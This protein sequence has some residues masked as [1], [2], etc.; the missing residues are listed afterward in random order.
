[1]KKLLNTLY[2]TT[3]GTY[4]S[5][6]GE[7]ILV[8]QDDEVKLQLPIHTISAIMFSAAREPPHPSG[9]LRR[10]KSK[11]FFLQHEWQISGQDGRPGYREC[12]APPCPVSQ[13]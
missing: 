2:I 5:R 9:A 7:T 8:K 11:R 3:P 1:L 12:L 6:E 4:L 10:A 13:G